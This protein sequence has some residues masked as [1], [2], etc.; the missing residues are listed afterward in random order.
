M[1]ILASEVTGLA[2][3]SKSIYHNTG[4]LKKRSIKQLYKTNHIIITV[5]HIF[6]EILSKILMSTGDSFPV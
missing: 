5:G 6:G 4:K 2:E 1:F 3:E